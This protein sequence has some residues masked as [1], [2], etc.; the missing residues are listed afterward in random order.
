[1]GPPTDP[2][3]L[4]NARVSKWSVRPC[5][6]V[7]HSKLVS[8]AWLLGVTALCILSCSLHLDPPAKYKPS[9]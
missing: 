8:T 1:M 9:P 7:T 5:I 4:G 2:G 3:P 6:V